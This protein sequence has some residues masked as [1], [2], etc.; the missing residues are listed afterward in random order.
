MSGWIDGGIADAYGRLH[1]LGWAHSVEAWDQDGLAGGLYGVAIAGLF[2]AESMFYRRTDASK[3]AFVVLVQLLRAA[4]TPERR[5]LDLQWLTPHLT[6]LGA[7]E[8]SRAEYRRRLGAA[9]PLR[10]PFV[11]TWVHG[12]R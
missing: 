11:R 1:E 10:S 9:L 2:A 4:G 12:H 3:A 8:I 6:T 7:V 5:V